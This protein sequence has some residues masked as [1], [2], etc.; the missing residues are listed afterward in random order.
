M[1]KF[2]LGF[3]ALLSI[4]D[5]AL[6]GSGASELERESCV[7]GRL[8]QSCNV[9]GSREAGLMQ[10]PVTHM[11]SLL[12]RSAP[13]RALPGCQA[14]ILST[15]AGSS[16]RPIGPRYVPLSY[17]MDLLREVLC[18]TGALFSS[19]S[20]RAPVRRSGRPGSRPD[21]RAAAELAVVLDP[22][23]GE[24]DLEFGEE[25]AEHVPDARLPSER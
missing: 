5:K 23:D 25:R 1:A 13:V 18:V 16:E 3:I 8:D 9:L 11:P 24:G 20:R 2:L 10:I 22:G 6:F 17:A 21:E 12:K 19:P 14:A 7:F 15:T 4:P